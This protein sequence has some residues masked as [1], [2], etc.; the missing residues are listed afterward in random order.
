MTR[1]PE[2]PDRPGLRQI[3]AARQ[4]SAAD[5]T[6]W[7]YRRRARHVLA[8]RRDRAVMTHRGRSHRPWFGCQPD[9]WAEVTQAG[10]GS[11]S[12][13]ASTSSVGRN[14]AR[15]VRSS[16]SMTLQRSCGSVRC[17]GPARQR[18]RPPRNQPAAPAETWTSVRQRPALLALPQRV[19]S[20]PA[21]AT[22]VT[23]LRWEMRHRRPPGATKM[24]RLWAS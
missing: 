9:P 8:R 6:A 1:L 11:P 7:G 4:G 19:A 10:D 13:T 2:I 3:G 21:S 20:C 23:S 14:G 17:V 22:K 16:R 5:P 18:P 12:S 24:T 15:Q